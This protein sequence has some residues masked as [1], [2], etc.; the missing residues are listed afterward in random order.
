MGMGLKRLRG[1]RIMAFLRLLLRQN[2]TSHT[3]EQTMTTNALRATIPSIAGISLPISSR[4]SE[5]S[6]EIENDGATEPP[7]SPVKVIFV[8]GLPPQVRWNSMEAS[9]ASTTDN[10]F[11]YGSPITP[12]A[13][14][15]PK[16]YI[17]YTE[18]KKL[19]PTIQSLIE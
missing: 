10:N 17:E 11:I 2:E 5:M 3:I 12:L 9:S 1:V 15:S 4:D 16:S 13:S 7:S 19:S 18:R 14:K 8:F 6:L